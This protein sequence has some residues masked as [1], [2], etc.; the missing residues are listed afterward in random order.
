MAK[1]RVSVAPTLRQARPSYPRALRSVVRS[2]AIIAA[3]RREVFGAASFRI[4]PM[5]QKPA[6]DVGAHPRLV[7]CISELAV[8]GAGRSHMQR[9]DQRPAGR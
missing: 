8:T 6:F 7:L 1:W 9:R 2:V 4:V 3:E 5:L